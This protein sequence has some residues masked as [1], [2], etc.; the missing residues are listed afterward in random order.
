MDAEWQL[1]VDIVAKVATAKLWNRN[2]KRSKSG[3]MDF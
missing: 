1:W 3:G 2:L